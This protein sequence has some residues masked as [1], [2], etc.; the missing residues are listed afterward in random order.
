MKILH[1]MKKE[2]SG[3]AR[4]TLELAKYEEKQGHEVLIKATWRRSI[5]F[6]ER[7]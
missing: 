2:N 7:D 4:T 5:L 1:Q 6:M 3:L